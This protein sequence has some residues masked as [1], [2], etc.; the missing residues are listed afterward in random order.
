M[1]VMFFA[2]ADENGK[3]KFELVYNKFNRLMLKKAYD[4]LRDYDLAQDAVSE[5]FLRV[6][7]NLH[8]IDDPESG[9]TAAFLIMIVKN[10]A[11]TML[12]KRSKSAA[13]DLDLLEYDVP[14]S[15][16]LE[17]DIISKIA[18]DELMRVIDCLKDELKTPFLLKY[19]YDYS[20]KEIGKMLKISEN[21]AAVRITRARTKL[22]KILANGG[23]ANEAR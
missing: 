13:A 10:A 20:L 11:I 21:N 15:Y 12:N 6:Y 2:F 3:E 4:I 23:Q 7:K 22:A 14:D 9:K 8:K 5:A 1:F 18:A 17:G 16:D 19:A